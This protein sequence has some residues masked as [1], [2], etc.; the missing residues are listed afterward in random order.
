MKRLTI[1]FELYRQELRKAEQE[2]HYQAIAICNKILKRFN[3]GKI[4]EDI[5]AE[6]ELWDDVQLLN[7]VKMLFFQWGK[8]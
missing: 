7:F 1:D 8:K 4:L 6:F 3:E 5:V 2:G